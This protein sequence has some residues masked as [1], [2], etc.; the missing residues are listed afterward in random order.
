MKPMVETKHDLLTSNYTQ[1]FEEANPQSYAPCTFEVT[2][3]LPPNTEFNPET[4][5]LAKIHFQEGPIKE[6]GV[7][8][9]N[10]EDA[11]VMVIRRLQGFQ[12]SPFSCRENAMA[13][14]K[15]E[16]ALMW[17]RKRTMNREKREVVGTSSV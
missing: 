16:E 2:R 3:K 14:T 9:I 4:D 17:L 1:V 15:L 12:D 6:Q 5:L 13:I 11:I 8:G 7:N 10:N